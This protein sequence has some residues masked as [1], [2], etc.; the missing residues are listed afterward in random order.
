MHQF[1]TLVTT[2]SIPAPNPARLR[3]HRLRVTVQCQQ[4][5]VRPEPPQYFPAVTPTAIRAIDVNTVRPHHQSVYRR[6]QQHRD[7]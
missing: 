7:M 6:I 5:S 2:I 3:H 4:P 1:E